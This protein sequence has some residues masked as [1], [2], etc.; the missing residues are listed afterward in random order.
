MNKSNY[1]F[2]IVLVFLININ[3]FILCQNNYPYINVDK[4][5]YTNSSNSIY[6]IW[7][8]EQYNLILQSSYNEEFDDIVMIGEFSD[9]I[10]SSGWG[11]LNITFNSNSPTIDI[12]DNDQAYFTGFIESI[13]TGDRISQM[14]NNFAAAEFTNSDHTPSPKL[15]DF[16]T[17]QMEF[18]REQVLENNGSSQ[19]W[20]S[21][22][23][24]MSQFDGLVK[25]YQQSPFPQL[26]EIE[27][28]I[29]TSAGDL[30]TL[31]SLFPSSSSS[32]SSSI[33]KLKKSI[34]PNF[35]DELT[36]CS[37]FIRVLPDY[38]DVYF[39]H[40]TWRY[41]YALLRIYKFINL[42]FNFQDTPMEYKVSF[43]SSPGF[44]SSKDDFYITG[45]KLAIM[46]TTNN[47]YN[48][49]LYQ[50][51]IPQSVLVWQRA[52]IA[53]MI[54]TN[55]SDWVKIFSEFNSGTYQNQ[56]MVFD[57]KLFTPG[58]KQ[59]LP[60]NTFWIAEQIPGQVKTEDLTQILNEQGYWKSYNI[61]YFQSIYNISGYSEK[62]DLP[63]SYQYSYE[64]CPRS[65]IFS[66]NASEVLNFED[67]KSLM[68]YNDYK[69]D[70]FSYSSPLNSISSRGDL[71][72]IQYGNRS[73]VAFGGVDSKITSFN[74]VSTLSCTAISGPSTNGGTLPPF[75]WSQSPLFQ[76]IT[77]IGVPETFNFDWQEMGPN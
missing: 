30:E 10:E 50:Y 43:S 41:Y 19:Y 42:Q 28:Y 33:T 7:S 53:N 51:T 67:M 62:I 5:I 64:K 57:Y 32:S 34:K 70:Q 17:T 77:H 20:Y 75:S 47:I 45:N 9:E 15:I 56:W 6:L 74:Q 13:L 16:L 22:G 36:D 4:T 18:V 68:Q 69:I 35:K 1:L 44:I 25:G 29:L 8:N 11:I 71:L 39:G 23:L 52:M 12:N 21:T 46:E 54:A 73:A 65:L 38:S 27:L 49:S 60:S 55:S 76:N 72:T 2:L 58:V 31:V 40:T 48:E 26:S 61:P 63:P 24:I 37:G 3:Y 59:P 66:R 14:Y